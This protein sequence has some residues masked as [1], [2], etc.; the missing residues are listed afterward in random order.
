MGLKRGDPCPVCSGTGKAFDWLRS[1][2]G[3]EACRSCGGSGTWDHDA[4]ASGVHNGSM[5][6]D[7][8]E[9]PGQQRRYRW[10]PAEIGLACISRNYP[11]Y[12]RRTE[13]A[14]LR[15]HSRCAWSQRRQMERRA[16]RRVRP[17]HKGPAHLE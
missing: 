15:L 17:G 1:Q 7:A 11:D 9:Y 5:K 3:P 8:S 16:G 14:G 13:R 12:R 4:P 10:T 2:W 6:Y